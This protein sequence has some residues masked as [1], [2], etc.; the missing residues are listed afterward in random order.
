MARTILTALILLAISSLACVI[1]DEW[2]ECDINGDCSD[3]Y[4]CDVETLECVL[5]PEGSCASSQDC[6]LG[7]YC[8][9]ITE[10]GERGTCVKFSCVDERDPD[11]YCAMEAPNTICDM[12]AKVCVRDPNAP[13]CVT[14]ADCGADKV[15]T[16]LGGSAQC[17]SADCSLQPTTFCDNVQ[18]GTVCDM[19][20]KRCAAQPAESP[21]YVM[22]Q[23][24][25]MGASCDS[26]TEGGLRDAGS[27]ITYIE[28]YDKFDEI[29]GYGRAVRYAQG[30]GGVD[31]TS[32][33]I[34]DGAARPLE[35]DGCPAG[36]LS[37]QS[38]VSLGCGGALFVEFIGAGGGAV[39][40]VSGFH[41]RVGE[42]GPYCATPDG[43]L[44]ADRYT[45]L[46]CDVLAQGATPTAAD[47]TAQLGAA[48]AGPG[49]FTIN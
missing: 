39:K 47:C 14:S 44:G 16:T 46:L 42:Y 24:M 17:V 30:D 11:A 32:A 23:D 37:Q 19:A 21:R 41:V 18:P 20:T 9:G 28:L 40:L 5:A 12:A 6:A 38:V 1:V 34:F 10:E 43:E 3:G 29:A 26:M 48:I 31:T 25:S 35:S 2:G 36:G 8:A 13:A 15:C 22:I 27:D 45:V 7:A 49:L 4:A 33:G